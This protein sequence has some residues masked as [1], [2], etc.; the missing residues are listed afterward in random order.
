[1]KEGSSPVKYRSVDRLNIQGGLG[2]GISSG[3]KKYLGLEVQKETDDF[4]EGSWELGVGLQSATCES[5][6]WLVIR[7]EGEPRGS[8]A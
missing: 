1:M 4:L 5:G 3:A 2:A 6:T 7:L 8:R